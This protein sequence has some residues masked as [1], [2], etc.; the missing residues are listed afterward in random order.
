MT[1]KELQKKHK[2]IKGFFQH[3]FIPELETGSDQLVGNCIFCGSKGH[4]YVNPEKKMWDC[5][6]CSRSGG[7]KTFL[8]EISQWSL[9]FF[10]KTIAGK[11]SRSRG[12][13]LRTLRKNKIGFNPLKNEYIVPCFDQNGEDIYD[14]KRYT[15]YLAQ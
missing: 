11:L 8:R 2:N 6:K 7:F 14:L 13:S 10:E 12:I 5:K 1:P 4:F 9:Q 3:G 15:Q